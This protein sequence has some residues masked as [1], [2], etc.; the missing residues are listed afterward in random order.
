MPFNIPL[1]VEDKFDSV[2][3]IT[4]CMG[5]YLVERSTYTH[6]DPNITSTLT[7]DEEAFAHIMLPTFRAI[8]DSSQLT[9]HIFQLISSVF[10]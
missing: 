3:Q 4:K 8:K 5:L 10:P 6:T 2:S 9:S 1:C 7:L